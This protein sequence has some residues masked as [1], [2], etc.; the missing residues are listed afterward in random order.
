MARTPEEEANL[1]LVM[2]M[3]ENVL[4]PLDS[5]RVDEYIAEDYIQ[6]HQNVE[7][8]RE[9]L[10]GFLDWAK[11][12]P[13]EAEQVLHRAFVDGDHVM[14][15]YHV[16]RHEGDPGFAVMD[17]FRVADGKIV[18]HWDVMQDVDPDRLNPLSPF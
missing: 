12:Q 14:L 16:I 18:E 10:K 4:V 1:A 15:H 11:G 8:G 13:G 7:P 6:H 5:A 2:G 3:F 17:I 9:A